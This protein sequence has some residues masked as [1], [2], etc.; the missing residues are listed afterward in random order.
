MMCGEPCF[1]STRSGLLA[2]IKNLS[3]CEGSTPLYEVDYRVKLVINPSKLSFTGGHD[4][5]LFR[6]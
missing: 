3:G 1:L 6:H 5:G 2:S 4:R